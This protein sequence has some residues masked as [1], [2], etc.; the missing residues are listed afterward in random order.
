MAGNHA[1]PLS[2]HVAN[3]YT[4]VRNK[5]PEY[6]PIFPWKIFTKTFESKFFK[7]SE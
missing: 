2:L 4:N 7:S 6:N 3:Y 1:K 5:T